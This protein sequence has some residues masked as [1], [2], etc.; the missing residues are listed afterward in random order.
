MTLTR[1]IVLPSSEATEALGMVIAKWTPKGSVLFLQGNLGAGKT[2]FV[3]G[4]LKALGHRA[5]VKSPTFTIVET[6]RLTAGLVFHFD[7]Y[8]IESPEE[9]E[10]LGINEYF[11]RESIVL[12]EWAEKGEGCLPIS[13]IKIAFEIRHGGRQATVEVAQKDN[14]VPLEKVL[15]AKFA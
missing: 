12:I 4:F 3:R 1:S 15:K 11:F 6:Y 10:W 14:L 5:S 13:D 2:T 8:R 9:L 7:L